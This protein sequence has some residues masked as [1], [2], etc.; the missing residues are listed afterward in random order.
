MENELYHYGRIGMKWGHHKYRDKFGVLTPEGQAHKTSLES[1]HDKLSS[2]SL[3]KK[4]MLKKQQIEKEYMQ[5]TGKNITDS[6]DPT[7]KPNPSKP[8]N[9]SKKSV[10]DMSNEEL[11][12]YNERKQLEQTYQNFQP[13]QKQSLGKKFVESAAKNVLA[14]M[15]VQM[16]QKFAEKIA[17]DKLGMELNIS[18][19]KKK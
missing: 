1:L 6:R 8:T 17:M 7:T 9:L 5:L 16:G 19:K 2:A 13:K 12:A 10:K 4:G 3:T 18:S 15:A 11:R 14:P